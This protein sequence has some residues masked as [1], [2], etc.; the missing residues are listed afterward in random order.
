MNKLTL[1][2]ATLAVLM[3]GLAYFEYENSKEEKVQKEEAAQILKWGNQ[4]FKSAILSRSGQT[5]LRVEMRDGKW[6]VTEPVEDFGDQFNITSWIGDVATEKGSKINAKT[7]ANG[8]IFWAEYGLDRDLTEITLEN[9]K[10]KLAKISFAKNATFDGQFFARFE[11]QV[12]VAVRTWAGVFSKSADSMRSRDLFRKKAALDS[13][14]VNF[15]GSSYTLLKQE[16][17]EWQIAGDESFELDPSAMGSFLRQIS[18]LRVEAFVDG[19]KAKARDFG[20][21]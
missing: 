8:D 6:W 2:F 12:Y 17:G 20:L 16:S 19:A 15:Q 11:N 14:A 18:G 13:V 1:I 3:G 10:G 21:E 7:T 4:K 5:V 9:E